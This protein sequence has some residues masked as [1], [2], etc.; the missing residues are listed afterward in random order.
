M[1]PYHHHRHHHPHPIILMHKNNRSRFLVLPRSIEGRNEGR[2]L[3]MCS[4]M[5][6]WIKREKKR[7][8]MSKEKEKERDDMMMR[9]REI[10]IK[11]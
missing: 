1:K 10:V 8:T 2:F 5:V 4:T 6:V 7:R 9:G 3:M 11:K